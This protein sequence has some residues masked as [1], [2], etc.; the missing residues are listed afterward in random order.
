MK[1][2][3]KSLLLLGI[4]FL[5]FSVFLPQI[6]NA[7]LTYSFKFGSSG[8]DNDEFQEPSGIETDDN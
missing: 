5:L 2:D 1:M 3:K 7:D 8:T 6:I 4:G